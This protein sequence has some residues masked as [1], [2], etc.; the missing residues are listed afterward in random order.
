M[1]TVATLAAF[2]EEGDLSRFLEPENVQIA[3][4]DADMFKD[5]EEEGDGAET[6]EFEAERLCRFWGL[7]D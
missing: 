1:R 5:E 4:E 3:A 6:E 7:K 2:G